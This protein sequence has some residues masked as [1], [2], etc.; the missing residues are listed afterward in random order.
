MDQSDDALGL[1]GSIR[2]GALSARDAMAAAMRRAEAA[3][4]LGAIRFLDAER[5]LRQAE[6][7]DV[8]LRRDPA[9]AATMPFFGVPFLMKDLG[10]VAAGF[11]VVAGSRLLRD[12]P[13]PTISS[14]LA[15][16]FEAAG[17][18]LFGVTTVPEFGMT[19]ATEPALGPVARNPFDLDRTPGGSSGGAAAAVAAGI[20]ALAQ[21]GD[22]GGSTRVPAACCGLV[23]LKPTRAAIPGGPAFG[24]HLQGL[25]CEGVLSRSLRDT[26]AALDAIAGRAQGPEPDPDLGGSALQ[27]LSRPVAPLRIGWCVEGPP[28]FPIEPERQR[29]V[30]AAGAVLSAAG[31]DLVPVDPE[32]LAVF[33]TKATLV[34]D[35]IIAV[36]AAR[37]LADADLTKVEPLTRAVV[38]RGLAISGVSLGVA[39]AAGVAV[40]HGMWRLF[41]EIDLLLTP[42]LATPPPPLGSFPMIDGDVD[43]NW[44]RM[45]AFAPYA[46]LANVAGI[47]ALSV[48][49]G[50]DGAGLPLAVQLMGAMGTD[51]RLLAV[52]GQ[53]ELLAR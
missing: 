40:A 48:P 38:A 21:S 2:A 12:A 16:R 29:A 11:P 36:N 44:R 25:A 6:A 50:R 18:V 52:A 30:A 20:V 10:A 1:A 39:L 26:A 3:S 43:A 35:H 51:A 9:R 45:N 15:R 13:V 34:F 7:L 4:H 47:P 37:H 32:R 5:G 33:T 42:M 14:D 22:A 49:R 31:H 46:M 24:N 17:L 28:E 41:D 27:L 19:L 23:G 8:L 53:L